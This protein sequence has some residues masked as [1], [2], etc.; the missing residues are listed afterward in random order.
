MRAKIKDF[1]SLDGV[2]GISAFQVLIK[3]IYISFFSCKFFRIFAHQNSGSGLAF[4]EIA[5][6]ES[7]SALKFE[8]N[9]DSHP[10]VNFS[11]L[12]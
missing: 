1:C 12:Y 6:F 9:A 5:G 3:K 7:G 4:T 10:I 11:V 2:L 8:I